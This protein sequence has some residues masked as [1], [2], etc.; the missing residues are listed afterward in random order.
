MPLFFVL[1]GASTWFALRKRSGGQ[2]AKERFKRL[3]VPFIFGFLVIVPPQIYLNWRVYQGYTG[4]YLQFYPNF[5]GEVDMGHLWFIF[6]LFFFSLITLLLFLYLRREGGQRLV[7]KLAGFLTRP[8]M[9]FTPVILVAVADYLLLHFYPNPILYLTFFIYG[10]ILVADGRFGEV[11]DRHKLSAL[12]LGVGGYALWIGLMS[13]Q[14]I[15]PSWLQPLPKSLISWFCLIAILG[16]G[17]QF[18]NSSNRF[19]KY[20]GEASY[21]VYILHQTVIIVLGVY[22]V[23]WNAGVPV[24]FAAISLG[25]LVAT[26]AIYDL[27]VKRTNITRFLFGMRPK[28]KPPA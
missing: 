22:V 6:F 25:S 27:L 24:K 4:S 18:L 11:I 5:F 9:I 15:S 12:I 1:A 2:Y 28:R 21:P 3:L 17:K 7:G 14:A 8:G 13:M 20:A 10:Y 19:L 16:Y 23:Q 26:T